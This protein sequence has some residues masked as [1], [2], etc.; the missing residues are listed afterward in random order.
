MWFHYNTSV[1]GSIIILVCSAPYIIFICA[2]VYV[3][4]NIPSG[5]IIS[6][7]CRDN[8]VIICILALCGSG[9]TAPNCWYKSSNTQT[10]IACPSA[11]GARPTTASMML[12]SLLSK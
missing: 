3:E 1:C 5:K 12:P 8:D 10:A 4:G 9:L 7:D 2:K 11:S 6:L